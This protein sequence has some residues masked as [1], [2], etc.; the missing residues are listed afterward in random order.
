M[1]KVMISEHYDKF[2]VEVVGQEKARMILGLMV[3]FGLKCRVSTYNEYVDGRWMRFSTNN[4]C[5][6]LHMSS[7][8]NDVLLERMM[9]LQDAKEGMLQDRALQVGNTLYFCHAR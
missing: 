9:L 5:C 8:S 7:I 3:E 6:V 2:V 4:E 1:D